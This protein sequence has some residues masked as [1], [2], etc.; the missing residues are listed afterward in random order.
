MAGE[1]GLPKP[2]RALGYLALALGESGDP[3]AIALYEE[4]IRLATEAGQGREVALLHN[5]F[6]MTMISLRGPV[7]ALE[8]MREGT[9]FADGIGNT[10]M[11]NTLHASMAFALI[12]AGRPGEAITL[13]DS[14]E[15][16]LVGVGD[17]FDLHACRVARA[18]ALTLVGRT[19]QAADILGF[20]EEH[21]RQ[22]GDSDAFSS[23]LGVAA[24]TRAALGEDE[25][26][27]ELLRELGAAG[28]LAGAAI[29]CSLPALV[30][31]AVRLGGREVADPLAGGSGAPTPLMAHSQVATNAILTEADG[32]LESAGA[33][34]ADA[35]ARWEA[36]TMVPERAFA[37]L[38]RGRCLAELG[39]EAEAE[40]VLREAHRIFE[41]MGAAPALAETDELLRRSIVRT[42]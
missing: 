34:Y 18:W 28:D 24:L 27:T 23:G 12:N 25:A 38:G 36:F 17:L 26:S 40:P 30:R 21:A 8:V 4:A 32:D 9:R 29:M 39:R 35:A 13:C 42:S 1:L 2:P 10:E 41:E 11:A 3:S 14:M 7:A 15:E 37:M 6:G 33:S 20:I 19:V 5:N 16:R 31:E 22:A